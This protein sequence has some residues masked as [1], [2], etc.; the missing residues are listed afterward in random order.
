MKL[1]ID[2][3]NS[4]LSEYFNEENGDITFTDAFKEEVIR[5]FVRKM[6]WDSEIRKFV[7]DEI[8]DG[9][10]CKIREWKQDTAIKVVLEE[11]IKQDLSPLRSGSYFY[12][13]E[14]KDKVKKATEQALAQ[15]VREINALIETTIRFE[16]EKV[17]R[18]LCKGNKMCEFLDMDKLTG[19]VIKTMKEVTENDKTRT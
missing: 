7:K 1:E 11:Q 8:K 10:G 15:Y 12:A 19:Y 13:Q 3:E 17:M 5:E 2:I 18:N 14:Y 6:Q 4:S 9:L 16:V